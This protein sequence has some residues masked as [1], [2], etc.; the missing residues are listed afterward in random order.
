MESISQRHSRYSNKGKTLQA[1]HSVVVG[2]TKTKD[3]ETREFEALETAV[4]LQEEVHHAVGLLAHVADEQEKQT[5]AIRVLQEQNQMSYHELKQLQNMQKSAVD[6]ASP[7]GIMLHTHAPCCK[8]QRR[9]ACACACEEKE[10]ERGYDKVQEVSKV[11]HS[12]LLLFVLSS[13]IHDLS[14][15]HSPAR[16]SSACSSTT[17]VSS[18]QI[19]LH[20]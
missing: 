8:N 14:F 5:T 15:L 20:M 18:K 11:C 7:R 12:C 1:Q 19:T 13:F 17:C 9:R 10:K 3:S 16:R 4:A 2:V 6:D